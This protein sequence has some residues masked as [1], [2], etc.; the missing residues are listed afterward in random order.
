MS[1]GANRRILG[2]LGFSGA[3]HAGAFLVYGYVYPAP[4]AVVAA[5][6][7]QLQLQS[8]LASKVKPELPDQ[9]AF[10]LSDQ[11]TGKTANVVV[12]TSLQARSR[13]PIRP[14]VEVPPRPPNPEPVSMSASAL[15]VAVAPAIERIQDADPEQRTSRLQPKRVASEV[16]E[17]VTTVLGEDA[18]TDRSAV[19]TQGAEL[20]GSESLAP[21][22]S[23]AADSSRAGAPSPRPGSAQRADARHQLGEQLLLAL[24][25]YFSYPL[26]ARRKGWQGEVLLRVDVGPDG[27]VTGVRLASSSGHGALDRAALKSMQ[28]VAEI[29][30]ARLDLKFT[31]PLL[32]VEIPVA[33]R[34][35]N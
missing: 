32:E 6:I 33:Y 34:L 21:L 17:A 22:N 27:Q 35:V 12:T 19:A 1:R 8:G 30:L 31:D 15:P 26:I 7:I 24:E 11:D 14:D 28:Q 9:T 29:D 23:S 4:Q 20:S 2:L 18:V 3:L 13:I 10:G 25:S 16:E 5:P